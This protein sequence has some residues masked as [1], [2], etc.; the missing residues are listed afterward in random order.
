M[1]GMTYE[2]ARVPWE[3]VSDLAA[4]GW[5]LMEIPPMPEM[6]NLGLGQ[7][8]MTGTVLFFMEREPAAVSGD[9]EGIPVG[10]RVLVPPPSALR[11]TGR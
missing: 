9:S 7:V 1:P 6:K 4:Q 2:Y 8:K 5:R 10:K 3:Q 11:V